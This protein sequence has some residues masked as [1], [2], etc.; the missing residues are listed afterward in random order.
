[1]RAML[2]NERYAGVWRFKE[3]QWVKALG[4][5]KRTPRPRDA[6]EVITQERPELRI[7]DPT[8]WHEV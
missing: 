6:S 4:S 2:Y 7:I 5:N 1:M 3:R 8:A